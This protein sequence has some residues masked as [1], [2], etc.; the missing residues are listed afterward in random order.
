LHCILFCLL[1]FFSLVTCRSI[2]NDI[3]SWDWYIRRLLTNMIIQ[4]TLSIG[5]FYLQCPFWQKQKNWKWRDWCLEFPF[6]KFETW[7]IMN[8]FQNTQKERRRKKRT[9]AFIFIKAT[10]INYLWSTQLIYI[11][12]SKKT[13]LDLLRGWRLDSVLLFFLNILGECAY[14]RIRF[15]NN[16]YAHK[17]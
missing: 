1:F 17:L 15:Y 3:S 9:H 7:Q 5:S 2:D 10:R 8:L 16:R 6:P 11:F 14:I 12:F 4:L 13:S